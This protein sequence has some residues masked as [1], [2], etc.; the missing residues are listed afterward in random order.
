MTQRLI[1]IRSY[2]IE[3]A[4]NNDTVFYSDL[5]EVLN[6]GYDFSNDSKAGILFGNELSDISRYEINKGRPL[7]T[8]VVINKYKDKVYI[9]HLPSQKF[10]TTTK[11]F[12]QYKT[13]FNTKTKLQIFNEQSKILF[14]FWNDPQNYE[15]HKDFK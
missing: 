13:D 3:I 4:K 1:K 6:L 12:K 5:S 15:N 10:Y 2:L 11:R 7:L 8:V 9:E 14:D